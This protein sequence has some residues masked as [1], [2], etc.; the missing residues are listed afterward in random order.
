[1]L[2]R[3]P[4][5]GEVSVCRHNMTW[6]GVWIYTGIRQKIRDTGGGGDGEK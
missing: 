4:I 5:L 6:V 1:M 3:C 2:H